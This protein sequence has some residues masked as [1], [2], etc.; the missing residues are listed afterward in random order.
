M[1]LKITL[2][3]FERLIING[4][5]I[6][7]GERSASLLIETQCKFLRESEIIL[8]GDAD[9]AAKRLCVTLQLIY[10][11]DNPI[12]AEDLFVRQATALMRAVPSTAPHILAI[13]DELAAGHYH[14]AIKRGRDLVAYERSLTDHFATATV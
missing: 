2:K 10:L 11:A 4:A 14:R 13:Q 9:T 6:R 3:P 12:E 8:E 1:P 5:A 7:N